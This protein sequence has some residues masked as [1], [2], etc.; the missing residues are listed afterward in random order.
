MI[1][2]SDQCFPAAPDF[3]ARSVEAI[4]CRAGVMNTH[5]SE[6]KQD[7][8]ATWLI[9]EAVARESEA[10]RTTGQ[11]RSLTDADGFV[12]SARVTDEHGPFLLSVT[13][14]NGY[15]LTR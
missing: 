11:G 7:Q 8:R 14:L 1:R 3:K 12:R 2:F 10:H 4:N 9:L 5:G 6:S 15:R 13:Y